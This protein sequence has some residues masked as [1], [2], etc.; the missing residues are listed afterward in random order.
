M[1]THIE[2]IK[3]YKNQFPQLCHASNILKKFDDG[4]KV[5]ELTAIAARYVVFLESN[6]YS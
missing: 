2:R 5:G 6:Q 4:K 3:E 1:N